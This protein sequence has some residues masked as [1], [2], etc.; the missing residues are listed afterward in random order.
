MS[1]FLYLFDFLVQNRTSRQAVLM[2]LDL[3]YGR[4]DVLASFA[5]IWP[6]LSKTKLCTVLLL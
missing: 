3:I 1:T 4:V 5:V 2:L 6:A